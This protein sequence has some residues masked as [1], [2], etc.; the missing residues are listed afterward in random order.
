MAKSTDAKGI[1]NYEMEASKGKDKFEI[2]FDA[3]GK[4]LNKKFQKRKMRRM[5]KNNNSYSYLLYN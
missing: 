4:L 3:N 5:T 1:V 2:S